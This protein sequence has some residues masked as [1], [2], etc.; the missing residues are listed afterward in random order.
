MS[1]LPI[2]RTPGAL[3]PDLADLWNSFVPGAMPVFGT[4]VIRVED[5][6]EDSHYVVRAAIPGLEKIAI[7]SGE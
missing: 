4:D 3:L 6:V 7:T 2:H 1:L 5:A